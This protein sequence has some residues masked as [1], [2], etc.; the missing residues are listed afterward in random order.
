VI[1]PLVWCEL[2]RQ[3]SMLHPE[4]AFLPRKFK[5]AVSGALTDRTAVRVHD[6]GLQAVEQDDRLPRLG[7]RRYGRTPIVGNLINRFVAWPH[8]LTYLQATLRVYNLH[9]RRGNKYKARIKILVRDLTPEGFA[10]QVDQEWQGHD[11]QKAL[12]A[13]RTFTRTYQRSYPVN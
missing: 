1:N 9:G 6:I 5:I 13:V 7:R 4:F 2:I 12:H 11:P 8:L 3:W 10:E